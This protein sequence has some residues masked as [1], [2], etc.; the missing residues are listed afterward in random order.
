MLAVALTA[1]PPTKAEPAVEYLQVPSAA[2]GR[3]IPVA[4]S[5]GGPHAVYLLDAFDA[6]DMSGFLYPSNTTYNGAL[7]AGMMRFG[8]VDTNDMWGPAQ[9]GRW[10]WHDPYVDAALLVRN[11]TRLLSSL[12]S[13]TVMTIKRPI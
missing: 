13:T 2:M 3:D 7:T 8:G 5:G 10:K 12:T 9:F 6:G 4:F 11:N 1:T